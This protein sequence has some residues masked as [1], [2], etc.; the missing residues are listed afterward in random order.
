MLTYMYIF[1]DKEGH[2]IRF[3]EKIQ[4]IEQHFYLITFVYTYF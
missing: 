1:I 3:G 2:N 4:H